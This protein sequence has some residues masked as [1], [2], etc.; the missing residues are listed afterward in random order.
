MD[1]VGYRIKD[2]KRLQEKNGT[3]NT[4]PYELMLKTMSHIAVN[5]GGE[6]AVIFLAGFKVDLGE[7]DLSKSRG[8]GKGVHF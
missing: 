2:L 6:V 4:M 7:Q 1:G 8:A 3:I 5:Q